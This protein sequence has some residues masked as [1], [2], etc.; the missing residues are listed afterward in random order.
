M[1]AKWVAEFKRGRHSLEDVPRSG[2][3]LEV[4]T[5]E[6]IRRMEDLV[7]NDRRLK[8]KEVTANSEFR[9]GMCL[10]FFTTIFISPRCLSH[11][12]LEIWK[13]KIGNSGSSSGPSSWSFTGPYSAIGDRRQE[14][15]TPLGPVVQDCLYAVEAQW[16]AFIM[17]VWDPAFCGQGDGISFLGLQGSPARRS[18]RKGED[19]WPEV[20][21]QH[22]NAPVYK[23]RVAQATISRWTLNSCL[24]QPT[25]VAL[26]DFHLFRVLKFDLR[27]K[28]FSD[29]EVLKAAVDHCF[30]LSHKISSFCGIAA[31]KFRRDWK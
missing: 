18:R 14:L 5:L 16:L 24:T 29:D 30:V 3:P 6:I 21:L 10:Q 2:R 1:V 23:S 19:C 9:K 26:S 31:L 17:E 25:D 13:C 11:V 7:K 12:C 4:T 22:D 28:R 20:C 27:G 8:M 15:D